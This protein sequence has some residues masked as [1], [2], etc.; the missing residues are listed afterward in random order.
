MKTCTEAAKHGSLSMLE[1]LKPKMITMLGNEKFRRE[2]A[3]PSMPARMGHLSVLQY[4]LG[5]DWPLDYQ[6]ASSLAAYGGHLAVLKW[7]HDEKQ[8][9][10][11]IDTVKSAAQNGDV[12]MFEYVATKH[13][14]VKTHP[15]YMCVVYSNV[16]HFLSHVAFFSE[17]KKRGPTHTR[18]LH[19]QQTDTRRILT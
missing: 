11:D 15:F 1:M 12:E 5:L 4:L 17:R 14:E 6:F 7:M 13:T 3:C 2:I 10:V 16:C 18:Q 8:I 19:S 9:P